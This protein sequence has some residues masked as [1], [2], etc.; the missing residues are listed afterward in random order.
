VE[1]LAVAR[2]N[3]ER[4]GLA[5][6]LEE[7]DGG[8]L[9]EGEWDLVVA[10]PPYV[11][12]AEIDSLEPEVRDWEPRAALD[13]RRTAERIAAAAVRAL[14]PGGLLVL[15][16]GDGQAGVADHLA[17]LGYEAVATGPDLSGRTRIVEGRRPA[18]ADAVVEAL[19]AGRPAILPTDTVYGIYARP[20]EESVRRLYAV[21]GRRPEQPT[22]LLGR[23]VDALVELVPELA[24]ETEAL[25]RALLPGPFTVVA[26]N[27]A[28]RLPWLAGRNPDAIGVRVPEAPAPLGAVLARVPVL[29]ATSANLPGGPD[30]RRPADLEPSLVA[31]CL[32][33][34]GGELPGVPSTVVDVTGPE[35]CVL[36]EGA[37]PAPETLGRIAAA[38]A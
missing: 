1:A 31:A 4:H 32:V 37:V 8:D 2:E 26:P 3:A 19:L 22:A 38:L 9:G 23:D 11:D 10:N 27:P 36:R 6:T 29:A 16:V 20:D 13:G 24:G 5:V 17:A 15:E 30:P 21:K 7:R 35:P 12:P 28:R 34:G 14:R 33:L 18:D 25:L